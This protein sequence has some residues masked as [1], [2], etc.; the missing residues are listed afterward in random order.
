LEKQLH[1]QKIQMD[2]QEDIFNN[3]M[4][5]KEEE[6]EKL[7]SI[8]TVVQRK[9]DK[10]TSAEED[11]NNSTINRNNKQQLL[12]IERNKNITLQLQN[13]EYITNIKVLQ[14]TNNDLNDKL[15]H[16]L[17]QK[18]SYNVLIE[19]SFH[20]IY[21]EIKYLTNELDETQVQKI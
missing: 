9:N 5:S 17:E 10:E 11:I 18:V 13:E 16:E 12:L 19:S 20:N 3:A 14:N 1:K 21:N 7:T 8:S 4:H 15:N 2:I 6:I